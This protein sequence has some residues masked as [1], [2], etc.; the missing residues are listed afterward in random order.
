MD[1]QID[2]QPRENYLHITVEGTYNLPKAKSLVI[3]MIDA[4]I[5]HNL[6]RILVDHLRMDGQPI[7]MENFEY[8]VFLATQFRKKIYAN[9]ISGMRVAYVGRDPL[10]KFAEMVATN[11]GAVGKSLTDIDE[12][13]AWLLAD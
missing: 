6:N 3:N 1:L 13:I 11:R 9:G 5:E 8:A 2:I 7:L 12:A 4:A 10:G